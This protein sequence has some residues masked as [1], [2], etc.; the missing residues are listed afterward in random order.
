MGFNFQSTPPRRRRH[1]SVREV[2]SLITFSIHASAKEATKNATT[3]AEYLQV[4]NPRLREGGDCIDCICTYN[5][6]FSIHASAKEATLTPTDVNTFSPVFSIHASAKEATIP[7]TIYNVCS[8]IFNPRLREGGD[9]KQCKE[10]ILKIF[11]IHA[12][13]KEAT[14]D[15][16]SYA[17]PTSIFNPRL[18]EG[19]D[20][21]ILCR[22]IPKLSIFNPRLREGGDT[23]KTIRESLITFSIHASAKEATC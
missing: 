8:N 18:R 10:L 21:T 2:T 13:A 5:H 20:F 1:A 11:S 19:G 17:R 14:N 22:P 23:E 3:T 12:S 15:R 16:G 4:F 7:D 6:N 9:E